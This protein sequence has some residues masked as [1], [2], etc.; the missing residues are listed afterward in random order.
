MITTVNTP[1][2]NTNDDRVELVEWHVADG[3]FVAVGQTLADVETSKAVISVEADT[4]GFVQ[5]L[6]SQGEV[7]EV[8]APLCRIADTQAELDAAADATPDAVPAPAPAPAPA[9]TLAFAAASAAPAAPVAAI[10]AATSAPQ[11]LRASAAGPVPTR[12]SKA[13][14][15]LLQER[16]LSKQD[17]DNAGLLTRRGLEVRLG[18]VPA[19]APPSARPVAPAALRSTAPAGFGAA[20]SAPASLAKLAEIDSLSIGE[21]GNINSMLTVRFDSAPIRQ[22]LQRDRLFDGSVQP[23]LIHEVSRLLK[24]WPQL[25]ACFD[26][27]RIHYYDRVDIGL[28][29]D[30]GRGLKVVTLKDADTMMP[31]EVH[32]TTMD[33]GMR[34]V[35]NKIRP[36]ELVG[37]TITITDLSG[38]DIFQFHPLINGRQS[39]IIGIGGD[40]T[41]A[42]HPMTI[43]LT[44]DHRVANGRE[45]GTFLQELRARL[46]A[47]ALPAST[48]PAAQAAAPMALAV[49]G[50]DICGIERGKYYGEF[51]KW[52]FLHAYVR[53]DGSVGGACHR[54]VN[55]TV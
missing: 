33:I 22:R 41:A 24:Q 43:S 39:A 34:Y 12:L 47:Y 2:I 35:E 49:D 11:P 50:C 21:S 40:S 45:V 44:F 46:L 19:V 36:D 16:G 32:E 15:R 20:R 14:E 48:A 9:P 51:G 42:G 13:A 6:Q 1:R 29:I 25:T 37:A 3:D 55:G 8:G 53:A 30:L 26:N 38:L 28:A 23:L 54:C 4:A 17:F 7:I 27:G 18:L 5:R 31:I 10:A 52:A